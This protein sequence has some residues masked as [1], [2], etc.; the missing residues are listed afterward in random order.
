[1]INLKVILEDI[2][3]LVSTAG[4]HCALSKS[5]NA[6][7][8]PLKT[9]ESALK[10][11]S[12]KLDPVVNVRRSL[13][14]LVWPLKE[15]RVQ[16]VLNIL[17]KQKRNLML[18]LH[19]DEARAITSIEKSLYDNA[20]QVSQI[21][22]FLAENTDVARSVKDTIKQIEV[23]TKRETVM[24]WLHTTSPSQNHVAAW[25]EHEP[26]TGDYL[27]SSVDYRRW[28][29]A[30]GQ[31]AWLN[32]ISGCGKTVLSAAVIEDMKAYC[33]TRPDCQY[34]YYYFD[35]S[36][37]AK[38]K[39]TSMIQSLAAQI[40]AVVDDVPMEILELFAECDKG[41]RQ[42]TLKAILPVLI[43]LIRQQNHIYVILD[44][45]DES[46]ERAQLLDLVNKLH[47]SCT[48][49][50]FFLVSRGQHDISTNLLPIVSHNFQFGGKAVTADIRLYVHNH[51]STNTSLDKWPTTVKTEI[52]EALV[53]GSEGM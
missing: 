22:V 14:R 35:F 38:R 28:K 34:V 50:H 24:K 33:S 51:L 43:S 21:L 26:D 36:D 16:Q 6:D 42:P 40:V 10:V 53:Q 25:E 7:N 20:S 5:L 41:L 3:G 45:L 29:D 15:K 46:S 4:D 32:G 2:R 13:S 19:A 1:M 8:G 27:L 37:T 12:D 44:A 11:L 31:L 17:Q 52:E 30:S 9:C 49:I 23:T 39:P 18:A 48:N 47:H